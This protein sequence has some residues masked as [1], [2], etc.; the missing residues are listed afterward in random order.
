MRLLGLFV[1]VSAVLACFSGCSYPLQ[2]PTIS[3]AAGVTVD[4]AGNPVLVI[5]HCQKHVERVNLAGQPFGGGSKDWVTVAEWKLDPP[6][7]DPGVVTRPL[8]DQPH[9]GWTVL[10]P[11]QPLVANFNYSITA[12]STNGHIEASEADFTVAD[13]KTLLPDEVQSHRGKKRG[14]LSSFL[15][16]TCRTQS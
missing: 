11:M 7:T 1:S 15:R 3:G 9:P 16:D 14:P 6:I 13:V 10:Q 4:E 5:A 8:N 2:V 12:Y